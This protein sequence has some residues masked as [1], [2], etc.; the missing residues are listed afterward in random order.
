[1]TILLIQQHQRQLQFNVNTKNCYEEL[2]QQNK[3]R[4]VICFVKYCN[5]NTQFGLLMKLHSYKNTLIII[6]EFYKTPMFL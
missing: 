6:K 5:D 3:E 2:L 1:M 4:K